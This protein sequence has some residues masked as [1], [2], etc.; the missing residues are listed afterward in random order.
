MN[1]TL[2]GRKLLFVI[3]RISVALHPCQMTSLLNRTALT[4]FRTPCYHYTK[5]GYGRGTGMC[6]R[7]DFSTSF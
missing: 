5:G 2:L 1:H 3:P 4:S 6:A 7:T